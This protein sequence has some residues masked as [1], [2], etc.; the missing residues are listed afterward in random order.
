VESKSI[1]ERFGMSNKKKEIRIMVDIKDR[2]DRVNKQ[3]KRILRENKDVRKEFKGYLD[4][5]NMLQVEQEQMQERIEE[6]QTEILQ[7]DVTIETLNEE[8]EK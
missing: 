2:L 6:K 4:T 8:L 1:L 3:L 5:S 7:T